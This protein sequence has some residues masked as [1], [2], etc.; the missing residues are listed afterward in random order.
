MCPDYRREIQIVALINDRGRIERDLYPGD[1]VSM[2]RIKN[3]PDI[4]GASFMVSSRKYFGIVIGV[5]LIILVSPLASLP[6]GSASFSSP[7][8]EFRS[9]YLLWKGAEGLFREEEYEKALQNYRAAEAQLAELKT[10]HPDW[11]PEAVAFYIDRCRKEI[12]ETEKAFSEQKSRKNP[13]RVHFIDVGQGD[14]SLIQCPDGSTILIDGG[15]P[16]AYPFLIDYLRK[17]GVK[18]IDLMIAT[19]PDGDHIGGLVKVMKKFPVETV[20]DSGKEHTSELYGRYL[21]TISDHP[22]I[23]FKLGRAGDRYHFGEV[24]LLILHPSASLPKDNNNCSIVVRLRYGEHSYLFTGDAEKE[25]EDEILGRGYNIKSTVLKVGHHGSKSSSSPRFLRSVSPRLAVISAGRNNSYG[26]PKPEILKRLEAMGIEV[27]R[28]DLEG[29]VLIVDNGKEYRLEFPGAAV[30]PDY[31]IPPE[32]A[33]QI[34]GDQEAMIYHLPGGRLYLKIPPE[35]RRFFHTEEEAL[36][37]GFR[38]SWY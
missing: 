32:N 23:E 18:K 12:D 24:E 15:P 14:S 21:K 30:Y 9:A 17:A 36:A 8:E 29:T 35:D 20:L 28:T 2:W 25:A 13:L 3:C 10:S 7:A 26:L 33:G 22:E 34:V 6:S 1:F 37:A 31:E 38:K 4:A 16:Y 19:H 27:H 11:R 5:L